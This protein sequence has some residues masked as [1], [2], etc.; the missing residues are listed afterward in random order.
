LIFVASNKNKPIP[1]QYGMDLSLDI[2]KMVHRKE[3]RK[4]LKEG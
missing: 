4:G 2:G 1:T 3:R